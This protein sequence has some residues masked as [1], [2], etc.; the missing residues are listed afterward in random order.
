L[1]QWR[2]GYFEDEEGE[3]EKAGSDAGVPE[4]EE[5]ATEERFP[6]ESELAAAIATQIKVPRADND[7]FSELSA[8]DEEELIKFNQQVA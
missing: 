8:N 7:S 4:N 1:Q 6:I 3:E 5:M 2:A